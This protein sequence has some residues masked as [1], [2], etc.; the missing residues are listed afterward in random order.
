[1]TT[2]RE[3]YK[4]RAKLNEEDKTSSRLTLEEQ[5][6]FGKQLNKA[7]ENYID[8]RYQEYV[9]IRNDKK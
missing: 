9:R 5:A 1:M 2:P 6:K 3:I 7:I 4:R 8:N